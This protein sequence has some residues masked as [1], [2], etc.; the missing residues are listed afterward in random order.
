MG[1]DAQQFEYELESTKLSEPTKHIDTSKNWGSCE[2]LNPKNIKIAQWDFNVGNTSSRIQI[3]NV[4]MKFYLCKTKDDVE[5]AV[6]KLLKTDWLT[7]FK[8]SAPNN[9]DIVN[10]KN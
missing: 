5:L 1:F 6:D 4:C 3:R 9:L 7:W 8:S 2:T 10:H